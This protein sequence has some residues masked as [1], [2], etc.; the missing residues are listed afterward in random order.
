MAVA[1]AV[2]LLALGAG[3]FE[4][5]DMPNPGETGRDTRGSAVVEAA[6]EVGVRIVDY[7]FEAG[8][9][10]VPVGTTITWTNLDGIGHTATADSGAWSSP[11]LGRDDAWSY[12]FTE[13]GL[14]TYFCTPH[15]QMKAQIEVMAGT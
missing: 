2:L 7:G 6:G 1:V 14:Y 9:L 8:N 10:R 15:P 13:P 11:V 12:T 4:V 3:C 5:A